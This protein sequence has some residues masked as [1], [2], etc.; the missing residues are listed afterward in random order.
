MFVG[1]GETTSTIALGSNPAG[2]SFRFRT[3]PFITPNGD[4]VFDANGGDIFMNS[5]DNSHPRS[6]AMAIWRPAAAL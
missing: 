1:D 5:G 6:F 2:P 3:N 4:V